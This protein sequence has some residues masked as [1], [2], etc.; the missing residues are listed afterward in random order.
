MGEK[1][2]HMPLNK[3]IPAQRPELTALAKNIKIPHG[4]M[5]PSSNQRSR[6][7]KSRER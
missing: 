2:K 3:I 4:V 6:L 5:S 7:C 1:E